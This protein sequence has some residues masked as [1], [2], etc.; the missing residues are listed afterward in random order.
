M[1]LSAF[2]T[3][4]GKDLFFSLLQPARVSL[5]LCRNVYYHR[6]LFVEVSTLFFM[7]AL[8]LIDSVVLASVNIELDFT[9]DSD[10]CE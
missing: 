8:S 3:A 6:S 10:S 7:Y 1:I 9:H 2:L 5:S 4:A